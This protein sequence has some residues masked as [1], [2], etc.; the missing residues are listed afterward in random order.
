MRIK[1][2]PCRSLE[3]VD[4]SHPSVIF[5]F[6]GQTPNRHGKIINSIQL[7][8]LVEKS[9]NN[10]NS[11]AGPVN[12]FQK[13]EKNLPKKKK[14]IGKVNQ[15][16]E[17]AISSVFN[18][19]LIHPLTAF[20]E[21]PALTD[22]QMLITEAILSSKGSCSFDGI[23]DYVSKRWKHI[24]RRDGSNYTGDCKRA[25]QVNL[26]QIPQYSLFKKDKSHGTGHWTVCTNVEDS[27]ETSKNASNEKHEVRNKSTSNNS[28][29]EDESQ[30]QSEENESKKHNE[31]N[32]EDHKEGS[33]Y[34]TDEAPDFDKMEVEEQKPGLTDLQEMICECINDNGGSCHFDM[35]VHHV[36]KNWNRV[37]AVNTD[38]KG[39]ILAALTDSKRVFK[40][41]SKR[42]GWWM[43]NNEKLNPIKKEDAKSSNRRQRGGK[44]A[45]IEIKKEPEVTNAVP[46][47]ASEEDDSVNSKRGD[48][49][50]TELQILIIES[51]DKKGG[52]ATFDQIHE[53]ILPMFDN[54]RRRDGS[55]YTSEC[56]R[57]IQASLSNNPT[58]RPFFKKTMKKNVVFWELA[59]R[60][61]EFLATYHKKKEAGEVTHMSQVREEIE[62]DRAA[63]EDEE[64][65]PI[66]DEDDDIIINDSD[67]NSKKPSSL[68][69]NEEMGGNMEEGDEEEIK[70]EPSE[71]DESNQNLPQE[72]EDEE[73][74]ESQN[75]GRFGRSR[76]KRSKQVPKRKE[77]EAALLPEKELRRKRRR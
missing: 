31:G 37:K 70:D 66:Q 18:K 49:P 22:I 50:M 12:G 57:A 16:N 65:D 24:K 25:I 76:D 39:A 75:T 28:D 35:I 43:I 74:D 15:Q 3:S 38:C 54:L 41:D 48:P 46:S 55:R 53:Y 5:W 73:D 56:K 19:D 68:A 62:D 4:Y 45:T 61:K 27:L 32:S 21:I 2:D 34:N 40:R 13:E 42:T 30:N 44:V 1:A 51:V 8:N 67:E 20:S 26:R 14:V 47:E 29:D 10:N 36:S 60:S 72:E 6:F 33:G 17:P 58:T 52:A 69:A 63:G 9:T 71:E 64:E 11:N 7:Q 59:T 23:C 77:I